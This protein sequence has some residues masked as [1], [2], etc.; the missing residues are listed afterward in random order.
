MNA[1]DE[2]LAVFRD[3]VQE[4][5]DV[6]ISAMEADADEWNLQVLFRTCHNIKGAARMVDS[7]AV[8]EAAHAL[9]DLF[10]SFRNGVV[11]SPELA[12]LAQEGLLIL[13]RCFELEEGDEIPDIGAFRELISKFTNDGKP[14]KKTPPP[15]NSKPRHGKSGSVSTSAARPESKSEAPE[16]RSGTIRIAVDKLDDLTGFA[17]DLVSFL[18]RSRLQR[19]MSANLLQTITDIGKDAGVNQHP[20]FQQ[21]KDTNRRLYGSIVKGTTHFQSMSEGFKDALR[22]LRMIRVDSAGVLLKKV[23]R[24]SSR[25][26]GRAVDF[27]I[28]G[29]DTE[30]DRTILDTLRD[31]LVH[32]IRNA[33]GHGIEA[34][35]DRV[36]AGKTPKGSVTLSA[37]SR[38]PWVEITIADDGRGIDIDKV[39]NRAKEIKFVT[40][41][42]LGRMTDAEVSDLLFSPG[43][44][45]A[46]SVTELSGRGVGLDVVRKNLASISGRTHVS[47]SPGG[48]TTF[49]LRVPLTRLT[50]KGLLVRI[51]DHL[52]AVPSLNLDSAVRV[53]VDNIVTSEG[54]DFALVDDELTPL[55][56]LEHIL[57]IRSDNSPVRP[58]LVLSDG[59]KR[60]FLVDEIMGEI[61]F[62]IQE[63]SW[64][65][66][67]LSGVTGTT[68]IDGNRIALVLNNDEILGQKSR[69][70]SYT[71]VAASGGTCHRKRVLVVDDSVTSRT[72]VRNILTTA[73]Y[74]TVATVDGEQG[75]DELKESEYD[76]VV[77]DIEMPG[78]DGFGL[79]ERIRSD[80]GLA[81]LPV[82]LVTSLANEEHKTRGAE[83]G[84]DSYI[85]KG[86]FD[87][88][89]LLAAV[90]RL[91]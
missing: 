1:S 43:F 12:A 50:T 69:R 67:Q 21:A 22:S 56:D 33:V 76:L 7:V 47:W 30:I 84:A 91:L 65:L 36:K 39:R 4:L 11:I 71:Q 23:V 19:E 66:K 15:G 9:E 58:A 55:A 77:S 61:E 31:P 28:I 78:L 17:S 34:E 87:Q 70:T 20:D 38:G 2:L 85:V 52:I 35:E 89:E 37:W 79:T 83:A 59:A 6:L 68:M 26:T 41:E 44:T 57:G 25:A 42:K 74:E 45:T 73:G 90:E 24:E 40:E 53:A 81:K 82:I 63:L 49:T 48:G 86:T 8:R 60:V 5:L 46:R 29:G 18:N 62:V 10:D 13:E 27:R 16:P 14:G 88:D 54:G 64:N 72:L 3:E 51:G 32:L 75:W 80:S